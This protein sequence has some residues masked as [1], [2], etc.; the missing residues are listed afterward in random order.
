MIEFRKRL[1]LFYVGLFSVI[2]LAKQ[3]AAQQS[4]LVTKAEAGLQAVMTYIN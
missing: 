3:L 4:M 2:Y 1:F